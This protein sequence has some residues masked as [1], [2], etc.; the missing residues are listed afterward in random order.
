MARGRNLG[1]TITGANPPPT[2]LLCEMQIPS[3]H[4]SGIADSL[5]DAQLLLKSQWRGYWK[6]SL[7]HVTVPSIKVEEAC[8]GDFPRLWSCFCRAMI[9]ESDT[10]Y[11]LT[12]INVVPRHLN[13][14]YNFPK[15]PTIA[16][17]GGRENAR[18]DDQDFTRFLAAK[19]GRQ[20][21]Q[22]KGEL[23]GYIIHAHC[24]VL[25][26]RVLGALPTKTKLA[27]FIQSSRKHWRKE[28]LHGLEDYNIRW[29]KPNQALSELEYGCD[30]YQNPLVIPALQEV[31]TRANPS[32]TIYPLFNKL[33]IELAVLICE[34]ICPADYTSND[35]E[36][37]RNLLFAFQWE[38]PDGFWRR[39]LKEDL[40]FELDTLRKSNSPVNWQVLGLDLMALVSDR[41][42]YTTNGLANRERILRNIIAIKRGLGMS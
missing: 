30:I 3:M 12:G 28:K 11:R 35:V 29:V 13:V 36:N 8:F 41:T 25:F 40:F 6:S 34:W 19:I 33:P 27:K 14:H 4:D 10:K 32:H 20:P 17:I 23:L 38:M 26:G 9:K 7:K 42:W 37:L 5:E 22:Y 15:D 18:Y 1:P 31:I 21:R 16:R 39:W 24:W 2:C